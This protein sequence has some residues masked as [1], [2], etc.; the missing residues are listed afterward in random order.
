MAY[1]PNHQNPIK[2]NLRKNKTENLKVLHNLQFK[3]LRS[4]ISTVKQLMNDRKLPPQR[5]N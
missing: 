2:K 1:N 4:E 5:Q 3:H